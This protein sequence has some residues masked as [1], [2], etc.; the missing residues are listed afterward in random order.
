[1]IGDYIGRRLGRDRR[2]EKRIVCSVNIVQFAAGQLR[3]EFRRRR[4][5]R[6]G[7]LG[8]LS[9]SNRGIRYIVSPLQSPCT[10]RREHK[11]P[12]F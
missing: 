6:T 9:D 2:V 12:H 10:Y 8:S 1:M 5:L 7:R 11:N 3:M 4:Q